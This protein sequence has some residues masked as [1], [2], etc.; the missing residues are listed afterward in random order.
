[1]TETTTSPL[2]GLM[3]AAEYAAARPMLFPSQTSFRW[4]E[5]RYQAELAGCG[6]LLKL[7]GRKLVN[8]PLFDQ[9]LLDIGARNAAPKK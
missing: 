6:A 3:P 2:A 7:N 5:R 4:T 9:A 1:M 8:P